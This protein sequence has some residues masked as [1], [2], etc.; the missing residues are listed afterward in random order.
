MQARETRT[1][2]LAEQILDIAD[3]GGQ[4]WHEDS[5]GKKKL[6]REA[7]LRSRLRVDARQ[8]QMARLDPRL[9]GDKQSLDVSASIM[10]LTPEERVQKALAL[11]DLMEKFVERERNPVGGGPLVYDPGGDLPVLVAPDQKQIRA[12]LIICPAFLG[13]RSLLPPNRPPRPARSITP[14]KTSSPVWPPLDDRELDSRTIGGPFAPE[15]TC[16]WCD[17][18]HLWVSEQPR[19]KRAVQRKKRGR[20]SSRMSAKH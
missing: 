11:F 19:P 4:D 6:D 7:V 2:L 17:R 20:S 13:V 3:D 18:R 1:D 14:A 8:W 5:K 15:G 10:M 9:W 12:R 16:P